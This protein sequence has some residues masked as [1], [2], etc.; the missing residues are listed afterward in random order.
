M[1]LKEVFEPVVKFLKNLQNKEKEA[2]SKEKAKERL[3]FVLYQD[4][5]SVSPDF[6]EMMKK[7]IIE[8]IKKYIEIDEEALEFQLTRSC[9]YGEGGPSLFANIPIKNIKPVAKKIE[10]KIEEIETK[11]KTEDEVA[12][13]KAE[14]VDEEEKEKEILD[15]KEENS[16]KEEDTQNVTTENKSDEKEEVKEKEEIKVKPKTEAKKDTTK[17]TTTKGKTQSKSKKTT[18]K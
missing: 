4:R 2:S 11:M 18:K 3:Q 16:S 14:V 17:K 12:T 9:E 8:V 7:E 10:E 13:E 15:D 6:F 5:A 1:E